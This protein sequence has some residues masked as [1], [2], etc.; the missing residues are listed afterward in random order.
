MRPILSGRPGFV[1]PPT[2]AW[3]ESA[4]LTRHGPASLA[5]AARLRE[6]GEVLQRASGTTR[7]MP[8]FAVV[9]TSPAL[10]EPAAAILAAADCAVHYMPAYPPGSEIAA[11][12]TAVGAHAIVGRQGRID[13][14]VMAASPALSIIARHGVGTDE[15]DLAAAAACGITVTRAT[16][17][18]TTA[19][20][21]HAMALILALTKSLPRLAA[22]A[23]AGGWREGASQLG[24]LAG[25]RLGLVGFGPIG[26]A[27]AR[28]AGAFAMPVSAV[29]PSDR[30][31]F[32]E[33]SPAVRRAASLAALLA[34]TDVLSL[35]C[36]LTPATRHLI[37]AA[38]LARLPRGALL[39]NTARGG[40]I[41]EAA[42]IAAL[43]S[44]ALAGAGLDV[45]EQEPPPADH[46]LRRH[47]RVIVTPHLAGV[48]ESS[49]LRM[50]VMAAECVAAHLAGR[51]IPGE[52]LVV[53]GSRTASPIHPRSR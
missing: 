17:S 1:Q 23:A 44:G 24:D 19:V 51:P 26:A 45:F 40:L 48:T 8:R 41:D 50:G 29:A 18:N 22:L 25:R 4:F 31:G 2:R 16:G 27:V 30:R 15:V 12:V 13:A 32:F 34:E 9:V 5:A 33:S 38:A 10:A 6:T 37:D 52:R 21:E 14:A 49:F 42:L 7:S 53:A 28:M 39:I 43:E 35:H 36:P 20:A 3:Q 46:P 11:L 47:P